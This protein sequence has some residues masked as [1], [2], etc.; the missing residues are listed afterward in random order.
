MARTPSQMI[1]LGTPC[2]TFCL[3]DT[4][5]QYFSSEQA[6]GNAGFLVIFM[7]NHCPFV[8]HI[9]QVLAQF[10][11]SYQ[12]KGIQ[13]V[14][15]N[16]NDVEQYPEDHPHQMKKEKD[17]YYSFPYLFDDTQEVAKAFKAACTPDFFLYDRDL[18]LVY[19]GQF[20]DSR[21]SNGLAVTGQS[22]KMACDALLST[23]HVDANLPQVPSLGC[24]IK[25]KV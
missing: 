2:P 10:A 19:R 16:A 20:D 11:L 18:K 12:S 21:P 3:P 24:N 7:C 6:L 17:Q 8:I 13:I 15:I 25:W 22:L 9:R 4:N 14:G 23:G 5:G 1:P